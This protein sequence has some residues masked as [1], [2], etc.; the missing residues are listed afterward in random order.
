[1]KKVYA[2]KRDAKQLK[3]MFDRMLNIDSDI[4]VIRKYVYD[5]GME[6]FGEIIT[7]INEFR[8]ILE[9][10]KPYQEGEEWMDK[11]DKIEVVLIFLLVVLAC[12]VGLLLLS[13]S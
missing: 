2:R 9:G 5:L 8:E 1:M 13:G 12:T 3:E 4:E 11:Q 10:K 6:N 7:D